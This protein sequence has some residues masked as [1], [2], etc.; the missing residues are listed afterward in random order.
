MPPLFCLAALLAL[1]ADE[2]PDLH[3]RVEGCCRSWR[4]THP[5]GLVVRN[6]Q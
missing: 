3:A 6:R 5:A 1:A 4:F 2:K